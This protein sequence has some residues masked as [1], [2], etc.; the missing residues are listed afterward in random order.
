VALTST[1]P[2]VA[3]IDDRAFGVWSE[4]D[5][6]WSLSSTFGVA[7]AEARSPMFVS[8]LVW[9]GSV[10]AVTYTDGRTF[11]LA[12]GSPAS[13]RTVP[14]PTKVTDRGDHTATVASHGSD[15]LLLTDVGTH[16]PARV[17]LTHLSR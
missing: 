1:G 3:G 15:L 10:L 16:A 2:V 9:T 4:H 14:L 11:H 17:W 6:T 13:L 8:A 5:G 7:R 12:L